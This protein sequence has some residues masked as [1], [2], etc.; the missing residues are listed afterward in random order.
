[1]HAANLFDNLGP[2][3]VVLYICAGSLYDFAAL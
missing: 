3:Q 2:Q 1:M